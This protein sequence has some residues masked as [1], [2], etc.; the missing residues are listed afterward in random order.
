[1]CTYNGERFL[2][3]QLESLLQQTEMPDEM[4]VCDDR[5]TDRTLNILQEFAGRAPFPVMIHVNR[6]QMGPAANFA[7]CFGL[8]KGEILLASDQD[9]LCYPYR[10]ADT[11]R[12]FEADPALTFVFSDAPLIDEAG[13]EM[14]RTLYSSAAILGTDRRLLE[15]GT[16]LTPVIHRWGMIYGCTLAFRAKYL[17]AALPV[18]YFW[19]HDTWIALVLS[20]LGPSR[21]LERPVTRYRQHE[22]QA[23]GAEDWSVSQRL[24][25]AQA[26]TADEYRL[27]LRRYELGMAGMEAHPEVKSRLLPELAARYEFLKKRLEIR[28]GGWRRGPELL[29]LVM[30][31]AYW[32]H[33]AGL[34][35]VVKD[36]ATMVR[37]M[38][39]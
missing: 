39:R 12:A 23:M 37:A 3:E 17:A 35:S 11:R 21:R 34:R 9:D 6:E 15:Q 14:G 4:V 25:E 36:A 32:R 27:E 18:P 13:G 16:A 28:N 8:C 19:G 1:M 33:G 10:I 26:R 2:P 20:V 24:K 38:P 29:S 7:R 30:R 22:A 5:S 31:G